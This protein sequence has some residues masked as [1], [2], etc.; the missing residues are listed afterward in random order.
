MLR[1]DALLQRQ[2]QGPDLKGPTHRLAGAQR[3][4]SPDRLPDEP[5]AA[6]LREAGEHEESERLEDLARGPVKGSLC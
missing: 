5:A 3:R 4:S 2:P 1:R 6:D